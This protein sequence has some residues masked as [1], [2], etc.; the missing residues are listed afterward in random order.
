MDA[1]SWSDFA[2][3]STRRSYARAVSETWAVSDSTRSATTV[4][5]TASDAW[6]IADAGNWLAAFP[7]TSS[8]VLS[9]S[10]AASRTP[11]SRSRTQAEAFNVTDSLGVVLRLIYHR[12]VLA[13]DVAVGVALLPDASRAVELGAAQV[14]GVY[15]DGEQA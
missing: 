3:G 15:M 12:A 5:R 14:V 9:C 6:D 11:Y 7:R 4:R 13:G 2:I 8:D 1:S 10:D